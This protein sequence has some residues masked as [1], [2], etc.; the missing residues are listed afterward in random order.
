[1]LKNSWNLVNIDTMKKNF[2]KENPKIDSDLV[3]V[4]KER[5]IRPNF[6]S[7]GKKGE[8]ILMTQLGRKFCC[9]NKKL[10]PIEAS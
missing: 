2:P 1:M 4:H 9:A 8:P 7:F 6:D 3:L 10:K 5:Y